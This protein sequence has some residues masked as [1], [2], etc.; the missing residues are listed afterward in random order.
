MGGVVKIVIPTLLVVLTALLSP[1]VVAQNARQ[2]GRP[3]RFEF[4]SEKTAKAVSVA[5]TFNNWTAGANPM[6]LG[7]DGR[8]WSTSVTVPYG[9]QQYKFVRDG[10][11]LA[12]PRAKSE[13][14]GNGNV[15][16]ILLVLPPDYDRP[17]KPGDRVISTSVLRHDPAPPYLN[18][19]RGRLQIR[20]DARPGDL[21]IV[22]V[23]ANGKTFPMTLLGADEITARYGVSL[24]WDRKTPLNYRFEFADGDS[25]GTSS[26]GP[27]GLTGYPTGYRLDPATFTPF[28]V[29]TWVERGVQYQI[30]PDR[31]ANGDKRNDPKGVQPWGAT[32]TYSNRFGGDAA[33]VR[34]HLAYL[35]DLGITQ[36][37]FNPIFASPSNHRY[38]TTDYK[39]VDPEIGTNAEFAALVRAMHGDGIRTVLDFA[40]NHTAPGFFAFEDLMK[41]GEG[42]KYKAWYFPKRF[43]I[44][45]KEDPPYEAWYGFPSM[46]KLNTTNPETEKYLLSVADYWTKD[47]GIDGMRLDVGNE[48]DQNF[49]RA[50]RLH[51]KAAR[52]DEWIIG[53]VWGDG[54]PWLKGD[55]WDSVMNY[56]FRDASLKF[57][58]QPAGDG[59]G[60]KPSDFMARLMANYSSYAPQ[61]SRN[62]MNLLG[63]HDTPRIL[64]ELK[65]DG[66]LARLAATVQFAWVG[67]PSVYYGDELGM[68]G[69]KDPDNRRAMRWDLA[70]ASNP[71]LRRYRLLARARN[72]SRALGSGDPMPLMTDD[73]AG[74]L[75]FARL[76]PISGD[77]ALVAVNRSGEPRTLT[78][79]LPDPLRKV[80][81]WEDAISGRSL[82]PAGGKVIIRLPA[83]EGAI[84]LPAGTL[85]PASAGSATAR[86]KPAG[87]NPQ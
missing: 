47:V 3:I 29:P 11:W 20:L 4:V 55:Q 67:M 26:F 21:A 53:E 66:D 17:A 23:S 18:Y 86:P 68:E 84:L 13:D 46:P 28:A 48:V 37:Y 6:T 80:S 27:N 15:N 10:E 44:V 1:P 49:W 52:P 42:S 62:L 54:S 56:P 76:D 5:G 59:K 75:A 25:F 60:G 82:E 57:F 35:K 8:T 79:S 39:R 24:P 22:N 36:V 78:I 14:D 40:F 70:T 77:S 41:N 31:F 61:V 69:G 85:K 34:A 51:V 30:F 16:S 2:T 74:T 65:G 87:V 9:R 81:V 64:T 50:M 71:F 63:S 45:V 43:P 58:G 12:D 7:P 33:G 73:A 38:E 72:A 32:P 19:D 83:K